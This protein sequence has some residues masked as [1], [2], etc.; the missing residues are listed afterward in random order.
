MR[1]SSLVKI[2]IPGIA[3]VSNKTRAVV[4]RRDAAEV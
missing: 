4:E 2:A 3:R 1:C